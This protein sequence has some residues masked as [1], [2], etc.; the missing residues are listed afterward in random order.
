MVAFS[1][2]LRQRDSHESKRVGSPHAST[3]DSSE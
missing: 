1:I 2:Y 3:A